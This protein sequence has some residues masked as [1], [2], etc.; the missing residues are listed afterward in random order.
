[1]KK[2]MVVAA[3]CCGCAVGWVAESHAAVQGQSSW[4]PNQFETLN[5]Q[6]IDVC[7]NT[8]SNCA[9]VSNLSSWESMANLVWQQAGIRF[10]FL[11]LTTINGAVY[12][13]PTTNDT[14]YDTV[15]QLWRLPDN[16]QSADP[17]TL[18]AWIVDA[19]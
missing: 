14:W 7:S 11:P 18:N 8:G 6:P 1:M 19:G 12:L 2:S 15:H 17:K 10:D 5:V 9:P 4:P 16:G 13:S 3:V